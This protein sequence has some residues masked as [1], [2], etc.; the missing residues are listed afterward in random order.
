MI[1]L[2]EFEAALDELDFLN[3]AART[4]VK[5]FI[6][7]IKNHRPELADKAP[8]LLSIILFLQY[9]LSGKSVC[10]R[11]DRESDSDGIKRMKSIIIESSIEENFE[12]L[13]GYVGDERKNYIIELRNRFDEFCIKTVD[14][15]DFKDPSWY[16][17]FEGLLIRKSSAPDDCQNYPLV[18]AD[19]GAPTIYFSRQYYEEYFIADYISRHMNLR[20]GIVWDLMVNN[21]SSQTDPNQTHDEK[22]L[23]ISQHLSFL[24]GESPEIKW[25]K[26]AAATA[27]LN[28]FTV[29]TGG[30]G[31][32]KTT[33]VVKLLFL[34]LGLSPQASKLRIGLA[35]PTG[36]A[37][38]RMKESILNSM[39]SEKDKKLLSN[40]FEKFVAKNS[41]QEPSDFDFYKLI[42]TES[43]TIHKLLGINPSTQQTKFGP[44][45]NI[46][47]DVLIVDEASMIDLHLFYLL[48]QAL[49]PQAKLILLGDKDQLPSVEAGS[50][51]ADICR[52]FLE[53]KQRNNYF[54]DSKS[55]LERLCGYKLPDPDSEGVCNYSGNVS[56]LVKSHRFNADE[57]IGKLARLVNDYTPGNLSEFLHTEDDNVK[58]IEQGKDSDILEI[59]D[60]SGNGEKNGY[61]SL[62]DKAKELCS[63]ELD[64][65][66]EE[67]KAKELFEAFNQFRVLCSNR[68]D[69]TTGVNK[70]NSLFDGFWWKKAKKEYAGNFLS[71]RSG[72]GF[73]YPGLPVM[74]TNND[75]TLNLFNGDVGIAMIC[76]NNQGEKE[77]QVLFQMSDGSFRYYPTSLLANYELAYAMTIHKSQGSEANRVIVMTKNKDTPFVTREILYT[78]ITR[79]KNHV[80][81]V[82]NVKLLESFCSRKIMRSSNLEAR[83]N[84]M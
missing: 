70:I 34:I 9:A 60:I 17:P 47:Y 38:N 80:T 44:Q 49:N 71:K 56:R 14:A 55:Y 64:L 62:F 67:D 52:N 7:L 81:L 45:R 2:K 32:G 42:P 63:E 30:P 65:S 41:S 78:G 23:A 1:T 74:V 22:F 76:D 50:V 11:L 59:L 61:K 15:L 83:L 19:F 31:T 77:V 18:I 16:E 20:Q 75:Y 29:I 79:A 28:N 21:H 35:A 54:S 40:Y 68:S 58:F 4:Y 10:L 37:A 5:F 36:K 8:G 27:C 25:Q 33:T 48:L 82:G 43:T 13:S 12:F 39:K 84:Q 26:V 53:S 46:P 72:G 24:F 66:R 57:G 73:W 69:D 51:L 3:L 6:R